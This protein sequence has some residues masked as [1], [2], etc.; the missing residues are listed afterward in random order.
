MDESFQLIVLYF[1]PK[2]GFQKK[3]KKMIM[4]ES[5]EIAGRKKG[6]PYWNRY[7]EEM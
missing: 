7:F 4:F 1:S 6:C 3:I 2:A 5:W